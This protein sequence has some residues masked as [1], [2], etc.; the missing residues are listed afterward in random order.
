MKVV[1]ATP[2]SGFNNKGFLPPLGLGYLASALREHGHDVLL[3]D[4]T[5]MGCGTDDAVKRINKI[6]PDAIG[7]TSVTS[8]RFQVLHCCTKLK[9]AMPNLFIFAGGPH[10]S[11]TANESLLSWE[12]LDA[13]VHGEG[14]ITAS[15]LLREIGRA[16]V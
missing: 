11:L 16:H 7:F 4:F 1:L 5:A 12:C 3:Y 2:P 6:T 13:V 8:D 15:E 9:Q 14:E 10:F